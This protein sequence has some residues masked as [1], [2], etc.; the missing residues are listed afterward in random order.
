MFR[1]FWRMCQIYSQGTQWFASPGKHE[2]AVCGLHWACGRKVGKGG[3]S[4]CTSGEAGPRSLLQTLVLKCLPLN[5]QCICKQVIHFKDLATCFS[6]TIHISPSAC[7]F[8]VDYLKKAD[9][10]SSYILQWLI[11]NQGIVKTEKYV[12]LTPMCEWVVSANK[13][14]LIQAMI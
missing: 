11:G 12:L 4:C 8:Q 5:F 1:T 3:G 13:C 14:A 7:W 9:P 6:I 2:Q 10:A